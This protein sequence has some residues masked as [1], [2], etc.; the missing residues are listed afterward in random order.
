MRGILSWG[1]WWI[2]QWH[3][4]GAQGAQLG[5]QGPR[6]RHQHSGQALGQGQAKTVSVDLKREGDGGRREAEVAE[7]GR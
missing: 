4:G 1:Q 6:V 5:H 7:E 3:Q 2:R